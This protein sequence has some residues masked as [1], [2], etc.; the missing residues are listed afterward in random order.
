MFGKQN[1]ELS[2]EDKKKKGKNL[3]KIWIA[4]GTAA[5]F[6]FGA[7][8]YLNLAQISA[9]ISIP[10]YP[11]KITGNVTD[12][13]KVALSGVAVSLVGTGVSGSATS[14]SDGN[15][16]INT[17]YKVS[18]SATLKATKFSY[19]DYSKGPSLITNFCG[20]THNIVLSS[21]KA[22]GFTVTGTFKQKNKKTGKIFPGNGSVT[23]RYK[24][25]SDT[26]DA[27]T[28]F[29]PGTVVVDQ[30]TGKYTAT[31][32]NMEN[33]TQ[34]KAGETYAFYVDFPGVGGS[35]VGPCSGT[36]KT[37]SQKF[38]DVAKTYTI[39]LDYTAECDG[40]PIQPSSVVSSP[41][42]QPSS[43]VPSPITKPSSMVS[44]PVSQPSPV[45]DPVA[46]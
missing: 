41:I 8:V 46:K 30:K 44:S 32:A 31:V 18:G 16:V 14:G 39:T 11:C 23:V 15:Y 34:F 4:S 24:K 20:K 35:N 9:D 2:E 6:V 27:V 10:T 25:A 12:S 45:T 3:K 7:V 5:A 36:T 17:S 22:G 19:K 29:G 42:T 26:G 33:A 13:S 40:T 38:S 1:S 37:A 21:S 43:I 28:S